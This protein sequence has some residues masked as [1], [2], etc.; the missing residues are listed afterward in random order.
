MLPSSVSGD[1]WPG[2]GVCPQPG[3][4][5]ATVMNTKSMNPDLKCELMN[6]LKF[7]AALEFAEKLAFRVGHRFNDAISPSN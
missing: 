2:G 3:D 7:I 4:V 5:Q 6:D 1:N